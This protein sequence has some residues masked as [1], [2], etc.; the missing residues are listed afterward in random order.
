[1]AIGLR[2]KLLDLRD[3]ELIWAIEQIWDI[4][5]KKTESRIKRYF[6]SQKSTDFTP[7]Y[8]QLLDVSPLEFIRFIS[9][10]VAETL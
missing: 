5:D 9:Y 6:K 10:E 3:G 1:M 2:L 4:A 7:M 8:R